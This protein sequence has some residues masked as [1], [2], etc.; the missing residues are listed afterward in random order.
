MWVKTFSVVGMSVAVSFMTVPFMSPGDGP[1]FYSLLKI[2]DLQ[3]LESGSGLFDK[4]ILKG[5]SDLE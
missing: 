4:R 2:Y 5:E 1:Q 3:I